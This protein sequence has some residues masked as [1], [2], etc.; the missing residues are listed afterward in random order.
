MESVVVPIVL[1]IFIVVLGICNFKG[2]IN[3]IHWYHRQRVAEE[4]KMAYAKL[5]GV[6]TVLCGAGII[7]FGTLSLVTELTKLSFFTIIGS[8]SVIIGLIIGLGISLYAMIKYNKGI[9]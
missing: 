4:N 1:G 2:I 7:V 5:M 6:G 9:F 3:S 8:A